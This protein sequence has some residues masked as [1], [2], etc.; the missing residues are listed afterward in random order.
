MTRGCC[1][2]VNNLCWSFSGPPSPPIITNV[3][4]NYNAIKVSWQTL[5]S[6]QDTPITGLVLEI[7]KLRLGKFEIWKRTQFTAKSNYFILGNLSKGT[8]YKVCLY[9]TNVAGQSNGSEERLIKTP[10]EGESVCYE[11]LLKERR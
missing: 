3:D 10:T 4:V 9:A 11:L 8:Y 5:A 2:V 7:K 1:F 6:S